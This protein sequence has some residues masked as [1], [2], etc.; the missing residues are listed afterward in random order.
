MTECPGGLELYARI[1]DSS[2]EL[3]WIVVGFLVGVP[4]GW[5]SFLFWW[6]FWK[7]QA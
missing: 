2:P 4:F 1:P 7:R 3:Q 5:G 6:F